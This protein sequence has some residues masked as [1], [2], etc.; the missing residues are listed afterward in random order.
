[1]GPEAG[2]KPRTVRQTGGQVDPFSMTPWSIS[3][4]RLGWLFSRRNEISCQ[5]CQYYLWLDC[6]YV[7]CDKV[8]SATTFT[9]V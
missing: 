5:F 7:I 3:N 9:S 6:S 4:R 8:L 2:P 1:M